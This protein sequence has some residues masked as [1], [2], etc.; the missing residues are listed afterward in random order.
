MSEYNVNLRP[1]EDG[2][3]S[4]KGDDHEDLLD[5]LNDDNDFEVFSSHEREEK[6]IF[7]FSR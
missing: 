7:L 3:E 2:G 4:I 5:D 1:D 6:K